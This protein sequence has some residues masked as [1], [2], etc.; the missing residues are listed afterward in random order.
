M[1]KFLPFTMVDIILISNNLLSYVQFYWNK[2][3]NGKLNK[4]CLVN[5]YFFEEVA[6]AKDVLC[7]NLFEVLGDKQV[8][9][10]SQFRTKK[11]ADIDDILQSMSTIDEKVVKMP[12]FVMIQ[13][14]RSPPMWR[15]NL[16]VFRTMNLRKPTFFQSLIE[17]LLLSAN[18]SS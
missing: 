4:C 2:C 5:F 16:I 14:D 3:C 11:E 12:S 7:K 17:W 18:C 1:S 9:R 15:F 13:L 8:R 6:T 10:S